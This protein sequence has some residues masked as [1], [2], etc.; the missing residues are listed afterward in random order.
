MSFLLDSPKFNSK[1]FGG[2]FGVREGNDRNKT[3]EFGHKTA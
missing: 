3:M 1:Y 2:A